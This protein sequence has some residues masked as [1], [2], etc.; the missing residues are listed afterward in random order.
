MQNLAGHPQ[1]TEIVLEELTRCGITVVTADAPI[2]EPKARVYG[3]LGPFT[4]ERA[5]YYYVV[6]GL[7]PLALAE[8]L[9]ADP[10]GRRD[11]RVNGHCACPAPAAPWLVWRM[12][13]G[14]KVLSL[15]AKAD[16]EKARDGLVSKADAG[17]KARMEAELAACLFSPQPALLGA[18]P[19]VDGYHVDSEL[20]LYKLAEG[21]RRHGLVPDHVALEREVRAVLEGLGDD[22]VA[23][24]EGGGPENLAASLAVSVAR[25]QRRAG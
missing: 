2:G 12:P 20:G 9:Y 19:F 13:D 7:V 17:F 25:L 23:V 22:Y 21:L 16:L 14:R 10:C 1:A 6:D 18:E 3:R 11:I 4:F 5:W 8:E 15:E 24:R